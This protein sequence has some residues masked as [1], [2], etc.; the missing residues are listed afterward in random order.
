MQNKLLKQKRK[1]KNPS[2]IHAAS[3]NMSCKERRSFSEFGKLYY[4]KWQYVQQ[5]NHSI[6]NNFKG[7]PSNK[8]TNIFNGNMAGKRHNIPYENYVV[9]Q[10]IGYLCRF[11]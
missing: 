4:N 5:N 1:T 9:V 10:Q 8:E 7:R 2:K 11:Q 3:N 6:W